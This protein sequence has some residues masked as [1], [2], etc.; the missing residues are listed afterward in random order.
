M[1]LDLINLGKDKIK[2]DK[3]KEIEKTQ[4]D[5]VN[6]KETINS[7]DEFNYFFD[8]DN[9]NYLNFLKNGNSRGSSAKISTRVNSA[10]NYFEN[11]KCQYNNEIMK[12]Q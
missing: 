8:K 2:N 5:I 12:I 9:Q 7:I 10:L 6:T 3:K 1:N 4:N 11:V